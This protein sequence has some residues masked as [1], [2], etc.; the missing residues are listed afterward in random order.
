MG[1]TDELATLVSEWAPPPSRVLEVGCGSGDLALRLAADGHDVLA[2]DPRAPDGPVFRRVTLEELDEPGR[3]DAVVASRSLHHVHDLPAAVDK[4]AALLAPGGVL[5]LNEFAFDRADEATAEWA[6]RRLPHSDP[7]L[8]HWRE[9]YEG[10]HGHAEISGE[11]RPR[12]DE[13]MFRWR[14]FV[15][16]EVGRDDVHAEEAGLIAAGRIRA[17]GYQYVGR[18][19]SDPRPEGGRP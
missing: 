13:L 10:L 12:F 9:H 2:I 1:W 14:P 16:L 4:L 18:P 6:A 8:E 5:V 19:L 15:G 11:L 17:L 3:F 7:S